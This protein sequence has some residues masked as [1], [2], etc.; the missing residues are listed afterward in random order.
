MNIAPLEHDGSANWNAST[1]AR[2]TATTTSLD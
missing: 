2:L 1:E